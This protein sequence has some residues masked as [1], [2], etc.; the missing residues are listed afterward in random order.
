MLASLAR[1]RSMPWERR[2]SVSISYVDPLVRGWDR[3]K[4]ILFT[5]P[6][7]LVRWVMIGFSAWIAGLISSGS[8]WMQLRINEPPELSDLT[9]GLGESWH[10]LAD[11]P[12]WIPVASLLFLGAMVAAV[13][14]LWV[15]SRGKL[16]FIDN[17]VRN[18]A[19]LSEP[20]KRLG[21]LGDS[22]FFWRLAFSLIILALTMIFLVICFGPAAAS[23]GV[24]GFTGIS[25]A[26]MA[27]SIIALIVIGVVSAYV[28]LFLESFV[29]PIM[30]KYN[31]S[32]TKAWRH[33]L[34]WLSSYAGWFVVYGLFMLALVITFA[35]LMIPFALLTCCVGPILLAIPYVGTVLLLPLLVT[36]RAFSIEFLAQ[37]D[38]SFNLFDE[39]HVWKAAIAEG[40]EDA[41]P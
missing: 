40:D 33:F 5:S 2:E 20:W 24:R 28:M 9:F 6:F 34:P 12:V 38:P 7:D 39:P 17:V 1:I 11:H 18:R 3:M 8:G 19:E 10:W 37:L 4:T 16:V 36:V 29:I 27:V 23:R 14:L 32:A 31:L 15:S 35:F 41:E 13:L 21:R 26:A 30:Y 22:L 25:Y